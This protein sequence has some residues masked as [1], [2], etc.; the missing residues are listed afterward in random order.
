MLLNAKK[1]RQQN[2]KY[3]A[4]LLHSSPAEIVKVR[5]HTDIKGQTAYCISGK[6]LVKPLLIHEE[7]SK[8]KVCQLCQNT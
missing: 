3:C 6:L 1:N 2:D 5:A 4:K 7:S 8:D